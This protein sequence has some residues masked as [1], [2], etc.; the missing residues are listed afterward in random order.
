MKLLPSLPRASVRLRWG[1]AWVRLFCSELVML[2]RSDSWWISITFAMPGPWLSFHW[3]CMRCRRPGDTSR[4]A[5]GSR[6]ALQGAMAG[7]R[8]QSVRR[9]PLIRI[10]AEVMLR[11][12]GLVSAS[13]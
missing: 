12:D 11:C 3:D 2:G 10:D 7:G 8:H 9:I 13:G 4:C 1:T 5:T 6:P